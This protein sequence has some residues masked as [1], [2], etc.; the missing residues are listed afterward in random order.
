MDTSRKD[1][2]K[3]LLDKGYDITRTPNQEI[4][5]DTSD[6]IQL[7]WATSHQRIIFSFN[8]KNFIILS[9]KHPFHAGILLANQ[10]TT[11]IKQLITVL[12]KILDETSNETWVGQIR[13]INDWLK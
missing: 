3:A 5:E 2:Y 8:I 4:P 6:E 1:L 7:L 12:S 9:R 10:S 11:T 13:W